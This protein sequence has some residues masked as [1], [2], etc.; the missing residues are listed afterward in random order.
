MRYL[1]PE[2]IKALHRALGAFG[3]NIHA[4]T[5]FA[6]YWNAV[7]AVEDFGS[8]ADTHTERSLVELLRLILEQELRRAAPYDDWH[9]DARGAEA[10]LGARPRR[11][12]HR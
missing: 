12:Q 2:L 7:G 8:I 1:P 6:R 9:E 5:E 3:A 10:F 4:P 11:K